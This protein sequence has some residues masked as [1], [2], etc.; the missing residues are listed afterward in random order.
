MRSSTW[1]SGAATERVGREGSA[2]VFPTRKSS[3]SN[4]PPSSTIRLNARR[5]WSES[6]RWPSITTVSCTADISR[7]FLHLGEGEALLGLVLPFLVRVGRLADLVALEEE[8][9]RDPLVRVDL[10]GQRRRVRDLEGH[11]AL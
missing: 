8:H 6:M 1:G 11:D 2:F 5:S 9:L 3:T 10:G 4:S 7:S